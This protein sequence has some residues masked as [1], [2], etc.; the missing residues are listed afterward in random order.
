M[1][2]L[3]AVTVLLSSSLMARTAKEI[4]RDMEADCKREDAV[5]A[6]GYV[7]NAMSELRL[8]PPSKTCKPGGVLQDDLCFFKVQTEYDS[9]QETCNR[10]SAVYDPSG[11]KLELA[12][13]ACRFRKLFLLKE[14][15]PKR[16][17]YF[18]DVASEL[19]R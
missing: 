6:S 14:L 1:K 8:A 4:V 13:C 10:F 12:F 19:Q 5:C 17:T 18:F 2:V 9:C 11:I 15:P 3:C 7:I 16:Q